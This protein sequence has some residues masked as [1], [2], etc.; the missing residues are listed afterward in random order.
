M[1]VDKL[2]HEF[3]LGRYLNFR[4]GPNGLIYTH[5]NNDSGSSEIYLHG[6]HITSYLPHGREPVIFLSDK[7]RYEPGKAIR[8]GI[9]I[10]W[11]WFADHPTDST[12]PAHGFARTSLWE[13]RD[14]QHIS[15]DETEITLALN[16]S[17]ETHKLWDYSFD[18]KLKIIVGAEL[19]A[20]LTTTNCD[21]KAFNITSAFHS[22]YNVGNISEVKVSGLEDTDYIDKVDNFTTKRQTGPVTITDETDR[23]YLDTETECIIEDLDLNRKIRI[24][25]SGSNSTVV[26]NPWSEKSRNMGDLPDDAFPSFACVETANAGTDNVTLTPGEQHG[27][28][29]NI[30][31]EST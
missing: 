22:Y 30:A 28:C 25:K 24:S 16:E 26:W 1:T 27:L 20:F 23:I 4:E 19:K 7:S 15:T 11:P 13:V 21:D 3:S 8:G 5:I 17:K 9:P 10:S 31:V 18:L 12:K 29:L 14:T 6:A 2:N